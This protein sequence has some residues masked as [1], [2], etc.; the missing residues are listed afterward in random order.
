LGTPLVGVVFVEA[1]VAGTGDDECAADD[2]MVP[3]GPL[4]TTAEELGAAPRANITTGLSPLELG[5]EG[6]GEGDGSVPGRR[7][8]GAVTVEAGAG[9]AT[10]KGV[11]LAGGGLEFT[12]GDCF[13]NALLHRRFR[14]VRTPSS[15][16]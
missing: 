7:L 12:K 1:V 3:T 4:A 14:S 10:V 8:A 5:T 13:S 2:W 9:P 15:C 11:G 16:C 6:K